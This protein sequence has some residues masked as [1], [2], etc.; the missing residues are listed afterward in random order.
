MYQHRGIVSAVAVIE[1]AG[2]H[3]QHA[4]KERGEHVLF[5]LLGERVVHPAH[6]LFC[7]FLMGCDAAEEGAYHRHHQRRRHS[8]AAHVSHAE[9][10]FVVADIEIIQVAAH[11]FGGMHHTV[12]IQVRTVHK[13]RE[14]LG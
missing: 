6:D 9:E 10:E 11:L 2:L 1:H 5:V 4:H 7:L 8:L 14:H 12:Y 13:G 3:I